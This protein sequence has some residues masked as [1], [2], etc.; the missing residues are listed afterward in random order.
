MKFARALLTLVAAVFVTALLVRFVPVAYDQAGV[1]GVLITFLAVSALAA[2]FQS[3]DARCVQANTIT[4]LIPDTYAALKIVSRELCGLIPSVTRNSTADRLAIGQTL[5]SASAPVNTAGKDITAAMSLPAAADQTMT[6][7][8]F[9]VTKARAFPF[10]WNFEQAYA[11]QQGPGYLSLNQQQIAQAIRAAVNEVS[12]DLFAVMRKGASRATGTAGTTPFA[13][14]IDDAIDAGKILDDNGT[15]KSDRHLIINTTASAKLKKLTQLQKV[16]EAGSDSLVRQG[17]LLDINGFAIREDAAIAPVAAVGTGTSYVLNGTHAVGATSIVVKTGTGTI[18]AG[19]VLTIN[20]KKYVVKTGVAAAGTLVINDPGLM[21][22]GADG[23]TVTVN[24][25]FTAN[26]AFTRDFAVLGTRLPALQP[27]VN[28]LAIMRE[29]IT[30]PMSGLSFE[31]AAYPGYR[32]VTFEIGL[33][34][35]CAVENRDHGAIVLG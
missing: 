18:L 4:N 2:P 31:L 20:S 8:D 32:M 1:A 30:D 9:T 7:E 19:D 5:R 12:A 33:A 24:A 16:N 11:V 25:A 17:I 22:A 23:N 15:A 10:S 29:T 13:S 28:D 3:W 35:G 34:W 6:T 14:T 26:L 21:D 27:N